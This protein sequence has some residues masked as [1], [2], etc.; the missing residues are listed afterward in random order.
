[1]NFVNLVTNLSIRIVLL[2]EIRAQ[3]IS[4]RPQLF[5]LEQFI[6]TIFE[7]CTFYINNAVINTDKDIEN[8]D[9]P[10]PH[11]VTISRDLEI[12]NLTPG[13]TSVR[14]FNQ[15]SVEIFDIGQNN[16]VNFHTSSTFCLVYLNQHWITSFP[17]TIQNHL[18]RISTLQ[19]STI[20]ITV[21]LENKNL[22]TICSTCVSE[23]ENLLIPVHVTDPVTTINQIHE[24]TL[25]SYRNLHRKPIIYP[26]RDVLQFSS[27]CSH[28][29]KDF[30]GEER[31]C[32]LV[33]LFNKYNAT[34]VYSHRKGVLPFAVV[35][36][37]LME[38]IPDAEQ[39]VWIANGKTTQF[40]T[41]T[42]ILDRKTHTFQP[43]SPL[44]EEVEIYNRSTI[45]AFGLFLLFGIRFRK[46]F[47]VRITK[48]L[49]FWKWVRDIANLFHM[50]IKPIFDQS[51]TDPFFKIEIE[52]VST[53]KVML[54]LWTLA[55]VVICG[56]YK[57]TL[58][59][60]LTNQLPVPT[61][62]SLWGLVMHT[63][64]P[65]ISTD[66]LDAHD[67]RGTQSIL[68]SV[69]SRD[70]LTKELSGREL[71]LYKKLLEKTIFVSSSQGRFVAA[72]QG[73]LDIGYETE[74]LAESYIL[75]TSFAF[76]GFES[77]VVHF[78]KLMKQFSNIFVVN[79]SY[80]DAL[81]SLQIILVLTKNY[82]GVNIFPKAYAGLHESGIYRI[83]AEH[84]EKLF[85][86]YDSRYINC[87]LFGDRSPQEMYQ[88]GR[89]GDYERLIK[90]PLL[91]Q[92]EE[93]SAQAKPLTF[94]ML[95]KK[96]GTLFMMG[97]GLGFV[98]FILEL[99]LNHYKKRLSS[100]NKRVNVV[101]NI[102]TIQA[103][104]FSN[105]LMERKTES[106]QTATKISSN[107]MARRRTLADRNHS[108]HYI[109]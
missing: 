36:N 106:I 54:G 60:A 20:Y 88:D 49:G 99:G 55:A 65:I 3:F 12:R 83:W 78:G 4:R 17:N 6:A 7:G 74:P 46:R 62:K 25:E 64:L 28:L 70:I 63:D 8:L 87:V 53:F 59:S 90:I 13:N 68:K 37:T 81:V 76:I 93:M 67:G 52:P 57:G 104:I 109:R 29:G 26:D 41:F 42:I 50:V 21:V 38:Y 11:S 43:G 100:G 23:L 30:R 56:A 95:Y 32:S 47:I 22:F 9:Y 102:G 77:G 80:L 51:P 107:K 79:N 105:V 86:D 5:P 66:G 10:I 18:L 24:V 91:Q 34:L 85:L 69:I 33:H 40:Y 31:I 15:C 98:A 44:G 82:F 19:T 72:Y 39:Y 16:S 75:P 92:N 73:R 97:S 89:C 71:T 35:R 101:T 1:M 96:S 48:K 58:T 14:R 61:P 27:D 2:A 84:R 103:S 45:V 108:L 94:A